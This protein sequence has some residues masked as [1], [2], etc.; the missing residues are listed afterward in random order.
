MP[1]NE[2]INP[3]ETAKQQVDI[4]A[5]LLGLD[6][7]VREVLK[8]PKRELTVNFPVRMDDGSY[9]VFTGYRVQ[10]NMARGPVQGRH[11]LPP[12]GDAGRG[13]GARGLDDL[14]VRGRQ[15]PV[16]R[17]QGRRH[18]RPE[19]HVARASS[20][21]SPAATRARSPRIIGPGDGHPGARR[22]HRL[23][24]DGVDHG[25]L[26]D[27]EGLLRPGRRHGQA[28][29][30]R[31][32]RGPRRGDGPRLRLRHPRGGA[33]TPASRSRAG[34]SRSRDSATRA[35]S[36][37]T[38]STTSR[39]RRSSPPPT[40]RAASATRTGST[41]T[42]SRRTRR[43]PARSSA[44]PAR[45]RSPTRRSSRRKVGHPGPRRA[46]E[47]DHREER[48]QGPGEDRRARPRTARPLPEADTIL[49]QKK[50]TVLPGH[51]RERGRR[52]REL[53]RVGA[54]HPRVLLDPRRGQPAPRA[55][56]GALLRRRSTRSR[57]SSK[58]T[59]GRRRTSS[60]SS[61]SSTRSA[62]AASTRRSRARR[63]MVDLPRCRAVTLDRGRRLGRRDSR[64]TVRAADRRPR[65]D[66]RAHPR[67][68]GPGTAPGRPTGR[69]PARLAPRPALGRHRDPDRRGLAHGGALRG[70]VKGERSSSWTTSPTRARASRSRSSGPDRRRGPG[71]ERGVPPHR[72]L[73][74]PPD[75]LR[76]GDPP[77]P[78][79][80]GRLPVELLGGP[81]DP[82]PQ[83]GGH[84]P[85]TRSGPC[86][87]AGEGRVRR[88][89]GRFEARRRARSPGLGENGPWGRR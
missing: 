19:A 77:G 79:G 32:Q 9:K 25:H 4:V 49:F 89:A 72:A 64:V 24:D 66:R 63:R 26:L 11:P 59:T 61:A 16:R 52:H 37:R 78:V 86:D 54:G 6:P 39:A 45:R 80:L 60:P 38:S 67:W 3:F 7:G 76:R 74:V 10:Y 31:R 21:A 58:S 47:P 75:L 53:L 23:P 5:D 87:P 42:R 82:R 34:P 33:R 81:C 29:Q 18:L 68:L 36:R 2:T 30:P 44:S 28:D 71:R 27:A 65:D 84:D 20:S 46:R 12:A 85:R 73:Q 55:G 35:A 51:P 13:P 22:L 14:E 69:P 15:H 57:R 41:R 48:R 40:P 1:S 83:G 17:R 56:H 62:S 43:R 8:H 50:I 70:P 88:S